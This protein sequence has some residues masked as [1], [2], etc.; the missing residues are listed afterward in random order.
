MWYYFYM[1]GHHLQHIVSIAAEQGVRIEIG[2]IAPLDSTGFMSSIYRA[3]TDKGTAI[4]HLVAAPVAEQEY[5]HVPE[6]IMHVGQLLKDVPQ[7]PE[8]YV[9]GR[10]PENG[11][12]M[13]Q[14]YKQGKPLGKRTYEDGVFRDT[15]L[16]SEP[17]HYLD[18]LQEV[19]LEIHSYTS[20][21]FGYFDFSTDTPT[22]TH[23]SWS[24][25][26]RDTLERS[27]GAL[28][29][30][31]VQLGIKYF[32]VLGAA[33]V[34]ERALSVLSNN[35]PL[36]ATN[37]AHLIHGDLC[38]Y[39][40]ILVADEHIVG[41]IDFEWALYGH[42]AWEFVFTQHPPLDVYTPRAV[43]LGHI[44][45]DIDFARSVELHTIFWCAW[46]AAVHAQNPE[47]GPAL[48]KVFLDKLQQAT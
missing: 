23:R 19:A 20:D 40:N 32:D 1:K 5:Q 48:Y 29:A 9:S 46:G 27:I 8:V 11:Y 37:L 17:E 42:P 30:S 45:A 35:A 4:I 43:E 33:E 34:R 21:T 36:F 44:A 18:E 15:F 16:V 22:G 38:N 41:V 14:E 28:E 10:L 7:V 25:F 47:F 13:V 6:K 12:F 24:E 31:E 39:S 3:E 26:L 2:S